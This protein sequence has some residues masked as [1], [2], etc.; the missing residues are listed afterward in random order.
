MAK[1]QPLIQLFFILVS[2]NF[3]VLKY[4]FQFQK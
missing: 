4:S 1:L 3:K 2:L